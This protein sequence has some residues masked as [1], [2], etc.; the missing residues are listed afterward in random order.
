MI[1][2][3]I[4]AILVDFLVSSTGQNMRT[5]FERTVFW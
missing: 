2:H 5:F 1:N 4:Y 3:V